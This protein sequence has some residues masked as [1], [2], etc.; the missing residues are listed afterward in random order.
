[1]IRG[2]IMIRKIY[3][4]ICDLFNDT[5]NTSGYV[6]SN[7]RMNSDVRIGKYVEGSWGAVFPAFMWRD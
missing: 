5:F 3:L 7:D 1:M 6:M 4:L 2:Y